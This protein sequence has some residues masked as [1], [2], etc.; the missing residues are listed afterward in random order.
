MNV[1]HPSWCDAATIL[2][3]GRRQTTASR[4]GTYIAVTRVWRTGDTIEVGL[5]MALRTEPL[6]GHVDV[7]AFL[8]GPI[9]LA[10]RLGRTG[11][12]PGAD[13]IINERTI[14]D[15]L[16]QEVDVPVLHGAV[17]EIVRQVKRTA[18]SGLMFQTHGIGY[19]YEVNLIPYYRIA[20]E[21]YNLYWKIVGS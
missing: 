15:L 1:R 9:V 18:G 21:R 7:V 10:G 11:I 4:P 14:G 19:P 13:I 20:H 12:A 6:P 8:Y 2:I 5:P 17:H 3:N 16:K